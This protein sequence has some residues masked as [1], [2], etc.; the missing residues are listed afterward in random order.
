VGYIAAHAAETMKPGGFSAERAWQ[1]RWLAE[2]LGV[3]T[4]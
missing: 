1:S 4:I 3:A 2:R